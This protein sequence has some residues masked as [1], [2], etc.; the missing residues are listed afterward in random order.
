MKDHVMHNQF[1][2]LIVLFDLDGDILCQFLPS[3]FLKLFKLPDYTLF[4]PHPHDILE[5]TSIFN[6]VGEA[7]YELPMRGGTIWNHGLFH[8]ALRCLV[9]HLRDLL[10]ILSF[11]WHL[12]HQPNCVLTFERGQ[13]IW[14]CCQLDGHLTFFKADQEATLT[15]SL[16]NEINVTNTIVADLPN[17]L[18]T[19]WAPL[20]I[21]LI[22]TK[23]VE[24]Y[25]L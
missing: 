20:V 22:D 14:I 17:I 19:N 10:Q 2:N 24:V 1:E 3:V 9:H 16:L 12:L 15:I 21:T 4:F 8:A 11:H 6:F 23:F 18:V 7:L 25:L 13:Q 5:H